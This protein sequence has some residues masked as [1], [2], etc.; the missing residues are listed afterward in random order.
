MLQSNLEFDAYS[1]LEK[2]QIPLERYRFFLFAQNKLNLELRLGLINHRYQKRIH[3]RPL[4]HITQ[5]AELLQ[6]PYF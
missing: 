6:G 3:I 2:V 5:C 4:L 1:H